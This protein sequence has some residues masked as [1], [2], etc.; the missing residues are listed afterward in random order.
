[1]AFVRYG[2]AIC[3]TALRSI[4]RAALAN[5]LS[6]SLLRLRSA[7]VCAARLQAGYGAFGLEQST[8]TTEYQPKYTD[9]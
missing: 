7:Q 8:N 2:F 6:T 4:R 1:M 3:T 9:P 5:D